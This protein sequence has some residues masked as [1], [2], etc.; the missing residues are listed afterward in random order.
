VASGEIEAARQLIAR[1]HYLSEDVISR[2]LVHSP[3]VPR[4]TLL[5]YS[6]GFACYSACN[7]DPLSRGIGVQN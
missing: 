7:V 6:R 4:D 3:F 1:E 2:M 5:T